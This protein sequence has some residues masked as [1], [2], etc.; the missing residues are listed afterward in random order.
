MNCQAIPAPEEIQALLD[1]AGL[2]LVRTD[3]GLTL[4][5]GELSLAG[6]FTRMAPRIKP[7]KLT[8]ELLVKAAKIKGEQD[9]LRAVDGT[10]GLGEDSFLLAAA[11]FQVTLFEHNPVIAAL[12][13]DALD[14][15]LANPELHE[16][17]SRMELRYQDS[18]EGLSALGFQPD[19]VLLDPMFPARRKSAS[20]KKKLQLLQRLEQPCT[21]E[22]T[23]LE[24][25]MA[26]APRKLIVKRP[27]KGPFLADRK[28]GYSLTGKA[29]RYDVTPFAR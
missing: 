26:T 2:S 4:T 7:G 28:P 15:A 11:G 18:V 24:A 19:V 27:P 3:E 23:L 10:A 13:G 5:D 12:L 22:E 17:A 1:R 14:R 16:V 6:D 8:G 25:A 9:Q 20:V 21:D 29:V